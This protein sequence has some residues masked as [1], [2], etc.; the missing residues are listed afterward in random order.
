MTDH[1][2]SLNRGEQVPSAGVLAQ[3]RAAQGPLRDAG[4]SRANGGGWPI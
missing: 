2:V 4:Q 1:F 3:K